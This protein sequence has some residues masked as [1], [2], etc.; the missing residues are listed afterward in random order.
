MK[1]QPSTAP[2]IQLS[3]EERVHVIH[4]SRAN[5]ACRLAHAPG[6]LD[7]DGERPLGRSAAIMLRRSVLGFATPFVVSRA[8]YSVEN[9]IASSLIR[10]GLLKPQTVLPANLPRRVFS[11]NYSAYGLA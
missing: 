7:T 1:E 8:T 11:A 9:T 10:S 5:R 2:P 3:A 4:D 6:P